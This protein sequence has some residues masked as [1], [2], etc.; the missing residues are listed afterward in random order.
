MWSSCMALTHPRQIKPVR[1]EMWRI[2]RVGG[3]ESFCASRRDFP[4]AIPGCAAYCQAKDDV[5]DY[6][7]PLTRGRAF[8]ATMVEPFNVQ[9]TRY[10][11]LPF[12]PLISRTIRS[13]GEIAWKVSN[14]IIKRWA[15]AERYATGV[16]TKLQKW[17]RRKTLPSEP[18]A[19]YAN[20]F[21]PREQPQV[22][23]RVKSWLTIVFNGLEGGR[24]SSLRNPNCS[25]VSTCRFYVP[26]MFRHK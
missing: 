6:E 15:G 13:Q 25:P 21:T 16:V 9:G 23:F 7:H 5:S 19:R 10:F 18:G 26:S 4:R 17:D 2:L 20:C 24:S 22:V 12:V 1:D 8:A 14:S 3:F 11:R